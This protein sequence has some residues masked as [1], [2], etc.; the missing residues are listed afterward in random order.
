M[1]SEFHQQS[2][3]PLE[4]LEHR[5]ESAVKV[6]CTQP[7]SGKLGRNKYTDLPVIGQ[8]V[9][10]VLSRSYTQLRGSE[11]LIAVWVGSGLRIKMTW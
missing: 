6:L 10:S 4:L 3:I 1:S 11:P 9:Q 8:G 2:I 7:L 5:K